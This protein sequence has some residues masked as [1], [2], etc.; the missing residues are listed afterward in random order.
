[1]SDLRQAFRVL[2]RSPG[3]TL[4]AILA[5]AP[6]I[7]ANSAIFSLLNAVSLRTLAAP[8]PDRPAGLS[9]LNRNGAHGGFR[10]A[11]FEEI[12]AHQRSFSSL[13][14]WEDSLLRLGVLQK[15]N[16]MQLFLSSTQQGM[17]Y[18]YVVA[19]SAGVPTGA[20]IRQLH[21]QVEA[22]GREYPVR[23]ENMDRVLARALVQERLMASL[24]GGF[25]V[26]ALLLAAI[27]LYGLMSWSVVRRSHDIGIR[28]A[29]GAGRRSILRMVLGESMA[30]V[31][32]GFA[33]AAPV[34]YAGSKMVS[35]L[36]YGVRP[37]AP[38]PLAIAAAVLIGAAFLAAWLPARRAAARDPM[39]ALRE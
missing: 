15:R 20:L 28:M 24:A 38:A 10:Y 6:G 39:A 21:A 9:T 33:L 29:L 31:A 2:A 34:V 5:L 36:L 1:M 22:L 25:G 13:F 26:L 23:T 7:G 35:A 18:P 8:H 14:V 3:F 16:P 4:T 19:R 11:E 27:G 17:M 12:R 30:L 37:L 32:A